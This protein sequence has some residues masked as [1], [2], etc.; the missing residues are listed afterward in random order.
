[1]TKFIAFSRWLLITFVLMAEVARA[2]AV[3]AVTELSFQT[4]LF[5]AGAQQSAE[6]N[7][8]KAIAPDLP[9]LFY[10]DGKEYR[11]IEYP[12]SGLSDSHTYSGSLEM[13][14]FTRSLGKDGQWLYHPVFSVQLQK[15][16]RNAV[17][18]ILSRSDGMQGLVAFAVNT[19]PESFEAGTIKVLNLSE[20]NVIL[21]ASNEVFP[22]YPLKPVEINISDIKNNVLSVALALKEDSEYKLVYRRKWSMRPT[23]RGIYFLYTLGQDSRRWYMKNIVL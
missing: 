20:R 19:T 10:F 17:V 8:K 16:W 14:F 1:M 9:D 5:G 3:D 18:V 22:L 15:S 7:D 13:K 12:V 4:L 21:N 6:A 11:S 2:D 23:I